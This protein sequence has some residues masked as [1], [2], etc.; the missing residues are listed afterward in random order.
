MSKRAVD[1]SPL[2]LAYVGD[3]V[4]EQ[5]VRTR[6]V[7]E[8][9]DLPAHK[10]HRAAIRYVSANAQS[11][12]IGMLE[13]TLFEDELGVYRRGRNA[14]SPTSAKNSSIVDYRRAT[15]FEA[16]VGYLYLD[17]RA[18]RLDEVLSFAFEHAL[19]TD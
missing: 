12:I 5:Y 1:Y 10:L 14:K 6:L 18:E 16:L 11:K 15:G 7:A 2:V 17:G 8:S 9:P 4:Y 13:E 19:I 3:S